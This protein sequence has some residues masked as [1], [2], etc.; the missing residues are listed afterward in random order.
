MRTT[1]L[2]AVA[3]CLLPGASWAGTVTYHSTEAEASGY[4]ASRQY[5][6]SYPDH[7]P[8]SLRLS[9]TYDA[10]IP[11]VT[12]NGVTTFQVDTL[13]I[14]IS[15]PGYLST[16]AGG[17]NNYVPG[18]ISLSSEGIEFNVVSDS[19][20]LHYPSVAIHL[21][22]NGVTLTPGVLPQSLAGL[23][24]ITGGFAVTADA[25][26]TFHGDNGYVYGEVVSAPEPSA[27]VMLA[28]GVV[29]IGSYS[30]RHAKQSR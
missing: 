21:G 11:G 27:I 18:T 16:G 10:S 28:L 22:F 23:E 19:T 29:V 3:L 5:G 9:Y 6:L 4:W 8:A 30:R 24:G 2:T 1:I 17:F 20:L 26:Y 15:S 7:A 13:S 12:Q 25:T 14:N